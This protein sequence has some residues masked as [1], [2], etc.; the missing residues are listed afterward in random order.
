VIDDLLR[1][2][3]GARLRQVKRLRKFGVRHFDVTESVRVSYRPCRGEACVIQIGSHAEFDH[4]ARRYNGEVPY[5]VIPLGESTVMSKHRKPLAT[6]I[7]PPAPPVPVADAPWIAPGDLNALFSRWVAEAVDGKMADGFKQ[8]LGET[9]V[10]V[11]LTGC[12]IEA[13]LNA[14]AQDLGRTGRE[15]QGVREEVKT[16]RGEIESVQEAMASQEEGLEKELAR[17][18]QRFDGM[19]AEASDLRAQVN[20]RLEEIAARLAE[21]ARQLDGQLVKQGLALTEAIGAVRSALAQQEQSVAG[22]TELTRSLA[23]VIDA[24]AARMAVLEVA[25]ADRQGRAL[26]GRLRRGL[27]WLAGWMKRRG[28]L[29]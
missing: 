5:Q 15:L 26:S 7:T 1:V 20:T 8:V 3:E 10:L 23:A 24:T 2:I 11:E 12:Q 28:L 27:D 17:L 9:E 4:F 25:E 6:P 14:Q 13:K 22:L 21:Q 16:T 18:D 29:R 19:L